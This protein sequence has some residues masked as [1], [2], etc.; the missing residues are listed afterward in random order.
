MNR[1]RSTCETYATLPYAS[2]PED[3][4]QLARLEVANMLAAG[5]LGHEHGM[6]D[7]TRGLREQ[8]TG[9]FFAFGSSVS[10][11]ST[12]CFVNAASGMAHDFDD[13]L[14]MGHTGHSAVFAALA[15]CEA[16]GSSLETFLKAV[17][18]ANEIEGRLGASTVLGP[19]N[20]QMWA[21]I[22]RAGAA[23]AAAVAQKLDPE[24]FFQAVTL[25]L[26]A[27]PHPDLAGFMGGDA[28]YLTAATPAA[29]G[30][31]LA[32]L[33]ADGMRGNPDVYEAE[34]GFLDNYAYLPLPELMDAAGETWV[35]RSLAFK[36][37]PGCAYLQAP[38]DLMTRIVEEEDF[39]PED[40]ASITVEGSLLT[41][42]MERH[43]EPYQSDGRLAPVT[44]TFSVPLSLAIV[45]RE[46]T[47]SPAHLTD[48][49]LQQHRGEILDLRERI[50]LRHGWERTASTLEGI[51]GG[52][53]L[54]ALLSEKG[55]TRALG[56]L[57]RMRGEH[58]GPSAFREGLRL[59]VG[60]NVGRLRSALGST[61]EWS[62]FD[63]AKARMDQVR[64]NFGCALEV[65]L[66]DGREH[67]R[68]AL[69]HPGAGSDSTRRK[70]RLVEEK[71]RRAAG[72]HFDDP[73][74][75]NSLLASLRDSGDT[76]VS[77]LLDTLQP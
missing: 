22:H 65:H 46:G 10:D 6:S 18:V 43:S 3:V 2:V 50:T 20:G 4:R 64:F 70:G 45:L 19:H 11:P 44:V 74:R 47:L 39:E 35:T 72:V 30:L 24:A 21:F 56:A 27:P 62:E 60:G 77:E 57:R 15:A 52:I 26:Y 76:P 71:L 53:D 32:R 9:P 28:K 58:G 73:D 75:G 63:L 67:R 31:R 14:Y 37:H 61:L 17:V 51:S 59:V 48:E 68:S 8:R 36:P 42:L 40:V 23:A 29:E 38:V 49:Y 16:A 54:N 33:A 12:A 7:K 41:L 1:L 34:D 13:Y 25:S 5:M 69:A 55:W 66:K